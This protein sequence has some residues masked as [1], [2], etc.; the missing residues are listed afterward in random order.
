MLAMI[1]QSNQMLGCGDIARRQLPS[2]G[3]EKAGL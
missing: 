3:L 2:V 1:V